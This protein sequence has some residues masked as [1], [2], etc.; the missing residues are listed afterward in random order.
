MGVCWLRGSD[1]RADRLL[2]IIM[3]LQSRGR[4]TT[5]QLAEELGVSRRTILRDVD[6][7]SFAG[8]PVYAEGGHGGGIALDENYRTSLTGLQD[9][10]VRALF[11]AS[12]APTLAEVGLGDAAKSTMLKLSAVLPASQRP[13]VEHIRQRILIDSAWWWR[14]D[15]PPA[16]WDQLQQAVYEDR[17]IQAV[18]ERHDGE[19]IERILEPYSLIAKSS[20]WY[21]LA[22]YQGELHTYRVARFQRMTLLDTRFR[23]REDFDLNTYWQTQ[24]Q[25]FKEAV[26]EYRFTLRVHPDRLGFIRRLVPGRYQVDD[27]PDATGWLTVRFDL[28]SMDFARMLVF[29]LG[30]QAVIVE[31]PELQAAVLA[32]ARETLDNQLV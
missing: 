28:E 21:L 15:Q 25:D 3:L 9:R 30:R 19:T 18:Y 14:D 32:A 16:F 4:L 27:T 26:S 11:V 29:G 17:C 22:Q 12:H 2:S 1:L 13:S 7:L 5:Q 23:R 10:E 24:L 6:A 31:P 20:V 8:V